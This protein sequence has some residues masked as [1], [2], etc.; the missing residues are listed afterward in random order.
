M[1]DAGLAQTA[2]RRALLGKELA[3]ELRPARRPTLH[4]AHERV[5]DVDAAFVDDR[6]EQLRK[7][8]CLRGRVLGLQPQAREAHRLALAEQVLDPFP[9]RV[10]LDPI[11]RAGGDEGAPAWVLLDAQLVALCA[12]HYLDELVL[13]EREADVV[14]AGQ[15]PLPRLDD[16]VDGS[17]LELGQPQSKSLPVELLPRHAGLEVRLLVADPAVARDELEAELRGVACLDLAHLA[18]HQVVVE[19]LHGIYARPWCCCT[20]CGSA[21]TGPRC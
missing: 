15:I 3:V 5:A 9:R 1:A 18:R 16:D 19:E 13:V 10:D 6:V 8:A 4:E 7:S 14:D 21:R 12:F 11:A 20:T 2:L 17:S